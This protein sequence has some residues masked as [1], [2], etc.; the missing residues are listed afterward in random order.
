MAISIPFKY[1]A[2]MAMIWNYGQ[3]VLP[4]MYGPWVWP[5]SVA[6]AIGVTMFLLRGIKD[7]VN[8]TKWYMWD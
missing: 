6:M 7:M 3:Y 4:L 2:L 5:L 8:Y 1:F